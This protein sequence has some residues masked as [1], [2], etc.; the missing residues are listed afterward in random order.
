MDGSRSATV[1]RRIA[2]GVYRSSKLAAS[3]PGDS[4]EEQQD[5]VSALLSGVAAG[6]GAIIRGLCEYAASVPKLWAFRFTLGASPAGL[7]WRDTSR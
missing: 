4:E 3:D 6:M 5:I 7:L 2:A 1:A